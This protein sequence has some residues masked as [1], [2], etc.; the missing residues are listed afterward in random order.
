MPCSLAIDYGRR[1][2]LSDVVRKGTAIDGVCAKGIAPS[3]PHLVDV[4]DIPIFLGSDCIEAFRFLGLPL[5]PIYHARAMSIGITAEACPVLMA[6]NGGR[7][8]PLFNI[9]CEREALYVIPKV[10]YGDC[11]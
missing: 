4:E 8:K 10:F 11:R 9:D 5:N 3:Q 1:K 6:I 7:Y 2:T